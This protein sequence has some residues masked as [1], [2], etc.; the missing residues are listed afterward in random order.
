MGNFEK[1]VLPITGRFVQYFLNYQCYINS[2]H[3]Q[4]NNGSL[5]RSEYSKGTN[6][7]FYHQVFDRGHDESC[8]S[9]CDMILQNNLLHHIAAL[10]KESDSGTGD[11]D[12]V[13]VVN[14]HHAA[15]PH[16]LLFTND[17]MITTDQVFDMGLL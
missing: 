2:I 8:K 4:I 5:V 17:G 7:S 13:S 6:S 9:A 10:W 16:R 3:V 11:D 12:V 14:E 15:L 1:E